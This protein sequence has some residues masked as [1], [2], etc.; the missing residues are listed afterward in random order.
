MVVMLECGKHVCN[1]LA[2]AREMLAVVT[3]RL[4]RAAG[5]RRRLPTLLGVA[6]VDGL[7]EVPAVRG[8]L[9]EYDRVQLE[10][11]VK[12]D[13][14]SLEL[15]AWRKPPEGLPGK[16]EALREELGDMEADEAALPGA[17]SKADESSVTFV[18]PV[19]ETQT[20]LRLRC[21]K[22]LC[23]TRETALALAQRAAQKALDEESFIDPRAERPLPFV[24]RGNVK[25]R[26]ER[27][28]LPLSRFWLPVR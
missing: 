19:P 23:P 27:I 12:G 24:P 26:A 7:P 4:P 22:G 3:E 14:H 11:T 18:F 17:Y 1:R 5:D 28:W 6:D 21:N 10:A 15:E 9:A 25:G 8:E 16:I 2:P 20:V 13:S